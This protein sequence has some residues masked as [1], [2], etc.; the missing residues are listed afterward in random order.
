MSNSYD[1]SRDCPSIN[2]ALFLIFCHKHTEYF[3]HDPGHAPSLKMLVNSAFCTIAGGQHG[4]LAST[5]AFVKDSGK[6]GA[7]GKRWTSPVSFT[8]EGFKKGFNT[9]PQLIRHVAKVNLFHAYQHAII[10]P[11]VLLYLHKGDITKFANYF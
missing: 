1:S 2:P 4:P 8:F 7:L 6:N 3:F 5:P 11:Y 10:M 9:F